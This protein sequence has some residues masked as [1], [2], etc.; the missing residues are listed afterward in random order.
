MLLLLQE[1]RR[2]H[3]LGE[4]INL[5]VFVTRRKRMVGNRRVRYA[6]LPGENDNKKKS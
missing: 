1:V 3:V 5:F 6:L 4:E 2:L